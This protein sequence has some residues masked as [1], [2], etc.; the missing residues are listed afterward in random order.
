MSGGLTGV[1]CPKCRKPVAAAAT[2]CP[3]CHSDFTLDEIAARKSSL[4]RYVG[5]GCGGLLAL[6][7]VIGLIASP[8]DSPAPSS[9][10]AAKVEFVP[11]AGENLFA[12][13]VPEGSDPATW[14]NLAKDKC[15]A[16]SFCWVF[17]WPSRESAARAMP[18]TDNEMA[19]RLFSY[20]VNRETGFEKVMWNCDRFPRNNPDECLAKE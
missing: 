15:G 9:E 17:A 18:M 13:I 11:M 3:H 2:R 6:L 19:Q 7:F 5:I 20:Q 10:A 12:M 4:K 16:N 8:S 1:P 14:P